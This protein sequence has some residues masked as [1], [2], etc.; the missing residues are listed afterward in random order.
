MN[1]ASNEQFQIQVISIIMVFIAGNLAV[2]QWRGIGIS[3]W[4]LIPIILVI[5]ILLVNTIFDFIRWM[6][7]NI[8]G[9]GVLLILAVLF[10]L[11][12]AFRIYKQRRA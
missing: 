1:H 4:I 8:F 11:N 6:E 5:G 10:I 2:G 9:G 7:I 12:F 3:K